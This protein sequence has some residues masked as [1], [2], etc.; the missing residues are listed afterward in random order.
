MS[1]SNGPLG[2][3]GGSLTL[4]A[5]FFGM[6]WWLGLGGCAPGPREIADGRDPLASLGSPVESRRY[7]L[8]YWARVERGGGKPWR[9]AAAFCSGRAEGRYPNC[10][11]VRMAGWWSAPPPM[12]AWLAPRMSPR[13]PTPPELEAQ[14]GSQRAGA[15]TGTGGGR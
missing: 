13:R 9:E 12:P 14:P 1:G 11:W 8:G 6:V 7:D 2:R 4:A 10:R 5:G 3:T 15:E